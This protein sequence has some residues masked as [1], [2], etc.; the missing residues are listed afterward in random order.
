[1]KSD[2]VRPNSGPIGT[3]RGAVNGALIK[4]TLSNVYF[5]EKGTDEVEVCKGVYFKTVKPNLWIRFWQRVFLG[6][7]WK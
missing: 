3:K 4:R 1:M 5:G 7:R 6:W 2:N